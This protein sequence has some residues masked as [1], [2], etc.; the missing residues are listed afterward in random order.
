MADI[1]AAVDLTT[2]SAFVLA[3]TI[4]IIGYRMIFKGGDVAK[5]VIRKA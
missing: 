1:F 3:A 5:Q 2:V 4:L